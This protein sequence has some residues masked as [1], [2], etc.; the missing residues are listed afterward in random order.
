MLPEL[1]GGAPYPG[2]QRVENR[3]VTTTEASAL[4]S[5]YKGLRTPELLVSD[6]YIA[7]ATA[8]IRNAK[9]RVYVTTLTLAHEPKT[10]ELLDALVLAALRG[11]E[12]HVAADVFTYL[13]VTGLFLPKRYLTRKKRTSMDLTRRLTE[14]G[15][16]FSWLGRDRDLPFRGRTH[17]KFC[18]VDDVAYSFGGVNLDDQ[19]ITNNDFMLRVADPELADQ[20]AELFHRVDRANL[21]W[22]GHR[23]IAYKHGKDHVLIDG[24]IVGDSIIYRKAVKWAKKAERVVLVSQYC[25]TGELGRIIKAREHEIYFNRPRNASLAN[26]LLIRWS[27]LRERTQ[28]LYRH[29]R[30]LHAKCV[31]FYLP[32]GKRV[33]ITGSHNF[34]WGGVVLGTREIALQTKNP[35]LI[36]QVEAFIDEHV[37]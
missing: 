14:A 12:V 36:D 24:G 35:D 26:R 5:T 8:R 9:R 10:D 29:R 18:V 21:V 13:D 28:S 2:R 1:R 6:D 3:S 37:R 15:V 19:G 4:T 20:L 25:P 31:V 16:H 27:M 22:R 11:I 7:D 17:T 34:V 32:K 30:Y 33:A 23:S